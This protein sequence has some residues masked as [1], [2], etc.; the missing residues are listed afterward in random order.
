MAPLDVIENTLRIPREEAR[1]I[2]RNYVNP[3]ITRVFDKNR[4]KGSATK[5][6]I[7]NLPLNARELKYLKKRGIGS[8]YFIDT[9]EIS[10]G[11]ISGDFA[12]RI[13]F[14]IYYNGIAVSATARTTHKDVL[15]K[16]WT[17]P[18]DKEVV[19][20]KSLLMNWDDVTDFPVLVE[21]PIDSIKGG[22]GFVSSFGAQLTEEQLLLLSTKKKVFIIFD[23]DETG[24]RQGNKYGNFLDVLGVEVEL[25]WLTKHHDLGE[26]PLD[27]IDYIRKDL[28]ME[29]IYD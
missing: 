25:L 21:G 12:H 9:Y 5:L 23:A 26:M 14:P 2:Y 3:H 24:H 28:E 10:S 17:L 6:A 20:H 29:E 27:D 1:R 4:T 11:G 8:R 13:V 7:P 15:P 18:P 16:Y 19:H 22:P